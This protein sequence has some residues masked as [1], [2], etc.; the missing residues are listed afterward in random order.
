MR[1]IILLRPALVCCAILVGCVPGAPGLPDPPA[2]AAVEPGGWDADAGLSDVPIHDDCFGRH[3]RQAIVLNE[4]RLPVYSEWSGGESEEVSRSLI[5]LE[6]LALTAAWYADGRARRY[7]AVGIP[8]VCAEFESMALVPPLPDRPGPKPAGP[9]VAAPGSDTLREELLAAYG[10]G[11]FP[12]VEAAADRRL[13]ALGS[14][15]Y[16]CMTRHLLESVRRVAWAAPRHQTRSR[17]E[18][19]PSP[20]GLSELLLRLNLSVLDEASELDRRAAP[21]QARGIPIL[22]ADVPSIPAAADAR[23]HGHLLRWCRICRD[24]EVVRGKAW[25]QTEAGDGAGGP[26]R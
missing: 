12:A 3:L 13:R 16:N 21:L 24:V 17:E 22:C 26:D 6:R 2:A 15:A 11:G 8:I 19:A 5:R 18:G 20:R 25:N 1:P 23:R 4:R 7:H 9:Y 14:P 10:S